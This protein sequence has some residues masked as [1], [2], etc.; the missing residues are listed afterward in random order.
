MNRRRRRLP[1]RLLNATAVLSMALIVVVSVLWVRNFWVVE[2][3]HW[4]APR[5]FASVSSNDCTLQLWI[6]PRHVDD[7]DP[8][9]NYGNAPNER[10]FEYF[11]G[12]PRLAT[13]G[14]LKA[15]IPYWVLTAASACASLVAW[16]IRRLRR[17]ESD[18]S[19]R[20]PACGYD[21]RATPDRC[22]EC[23]SV[24]AP[25]PSV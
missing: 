24:P 2:W 4:N 19:G 11:W 7:W 18:Y 8:G 3:V 16:G 9:W 20:C 25:P 22:P 14:E 21:L 10:F 6:L 17:K 23:G 15:A 1:R 13:D 12:V 5:W